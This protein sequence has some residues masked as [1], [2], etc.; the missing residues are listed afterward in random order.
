MSYADAQLDLSAISVACLAGPN[1]AGKSALLD[2]VTWTLWESARSSSDELIRLGEREMWVEVSF[3]LEK[4]TYRVK[5]SRLKAAGKSGGKASSKGGLELQMQNEDGWLSLTAGSMK[6]TQKQ[7]F[8]LLRMDY[9]TFVNSVYLRQGRADEFTTRP[10]SER[11]QLLGEILGLGYFDSLQEL[12]RERVKELKSRS[13]L[14]QAGL[15]ELPELERSI[16][17]ITTELNETHAKQSE[18]SDKVSFHDAQLLQLK[19]S[20]KEL[21]LTEQK[22]ASQ[23]QRASELESDLISLAQLEK[24]LASNFAALTELLSRSDEIEAQANEYAQLKQ[25]VELLDRNA[26]L[27]QEHSINQM[28]CRSALANLRSRLEVKLDSIKTVLT[29]LEGKQIQLTKQPE[30]I[31]KIEQGYRQYHEL[32]KE[33]SALSIRQE[34][35]TQLTSRAEKLHSLVQ[36]SRIRL[37]AELE[38]KGAAAEELESLLASRKSVDE[39]KRL[40]VEQAAALDKLEAEFE[41]V[42]QKGLSMKSDMEAV[43]LEIRGLKSKQSENAAKARELKQHCDSS[44]CPLCSAPIVDRLAVINRYSQDNL[45]IDRQIAALEERGGALDEE[46]KILRKKYTELKQKL[47][48]RKTLDSRIGQFNEKIASIERAQTSAG[49]LKE[50][51]A[52]LRQR[53]SDQD[54]AQVERESLINVKTEI[55]KLDFD[56]VI[57]SNLQAQIRMQR[58]CESR[59]Q[60]LKRD[61]SELKKVSEQ[62][63]VVKAQLDELSQQLANQEYGKEI[64]D[65]LKALEEK[66]R[67]LSYD[68]AAHQ[69]LKQKLA[70][71]ISA[72][73]IMRRLEKAR[74]EHDAAQQ[75]LQSC[76]ASLS[77]KKDLQ[78]SISAELSS[79]QE[80]LL[81]LPALEEEIAE[82]EGHLAEWRTHRENLNLQTAVLRSRLEQLNDSKDKLNDQAKNWERT[83]VEL[84]DFQFL[85]EAF[86][87]K[88]IQAVI[89]ENAIP[90]LESEANQILSRLSENQMHL[91]LATQHK[92]KSGGVVETLDLLI[93]D[94]IGTRSY[95]LFSGG[96]AFKVN[97][98]LR[99]AL[100]RLLARRAGAKLETLII[101][102]GFGSQDD[103][104][105]DRLVQAIGS[106]K[107][108]FAKILVIT[109]IA[110]V[111]ELFPAHINISK[112]DGC[113]RISI[114]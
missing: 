55:H 9:D 28:E 17:E 22:L 78:A 6:E 40:L 75:A 63:P 84:D 38:Q 27:L 66:V 5:R 113:S 73:E 30:E 19:E 96:E 56:P 36:E 23:Q 72:Q 4:R 2:A 93:G 110:E 95:E 21:H 68:P 31:E 29:E 46:R 109:H 80:R 42:E 61:Q 39:D 111:K 89:I 99:V 88:G 91:A 13:E 85:A 102:E 90:E 69:Q 94:A 64:R 35:F 71:R 48:G 11:K 43:D 74:N 100:S 114:V 47:D 70:E 7:I 76:H 101:D 41:L 49:E 44:I 57:Y 33:E 45:A 3:E 32:L 97:F 81:S 24:E 83:R 105:R 79:W 67:Q 77:A 18:I 103:A 92:T 98:A 87:K 50:E 107:R 54:F 59:Y 10:P 65:E 16:E 108:D 20:L 86:G 37:E 25:E 34:S 26:L 62:I 52:R 1:G 106:I 112:P 15:A 58:H 8:D 12:S 82:L 104:S 14:L 60:Q 51:V 53:L